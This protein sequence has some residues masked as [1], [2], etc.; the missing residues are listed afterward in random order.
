MVARLFPRRLITLVL[1]LGV[2]LGGAAPSW[3]VPGMPGK[4]TMP[5]SM[6]MKVPGMQIDCMATMGKVAP[7][8]NAPCK[9]T[10]SGCAVCTTCALPVVLFQGSSPIQLLHRG[11]RIALPRTVNRNGI[12]VLPALPP[13]I[14][15]T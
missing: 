15:V 10:D 14:T 7:V 11:Q 1:A 4:A 12:A 6:A 2:F 8:K 3:A 13:P 5:T 9:S